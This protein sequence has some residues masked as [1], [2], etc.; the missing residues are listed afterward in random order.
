MEEPCVDDLKIQLMQHLTAARDLAAKA[1]GEGRDLTG[2]ERAAVTEAMNQAKALKA[3]LDQKQADADLLHSVLALGEG[4]DLADPTAPQPRPVPAG[5]GRSA[6]E[7]FVEAPEFQTWLKSVAPS[8]R[9]AESTKG[10]TSPPVQFAGLKSLITGASDSSAGALVVPDRAP[11]ADIPFRPLTIRNLVTNGTTGSDTVE[12][13]RETSR[14]NNAAAVAE[15]TAA[16]G[17]TGTKPE[18]AF[19][20]EKVTEPVKTLAHWI[21]ATKRAMSD[22]A[23]IRTLLDSFLLSGLE[24]VLED[25]IVQGS[26]SGEHFTGVLNTSGTTAQAYSTDL[27]T[28]TRKALTACRTVGRA[29]PTAYVFHPADNEQIDL[30]REG[31]GSGAFLFGGPAQQGVQTLW[32]RPR[33]ESEAVPEGTGILADWRLA[34]LWDREQASVQVSDSHAD[35]F[36]RNL[37]AFL[38]EARAAFGVLR[39]AAFVEIDLTP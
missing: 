30:L 39:P 12:F 15:A 37:L 8:G 31:S 16:S 20:L 35:F 24:E 17:T 21:P 38:A 23:Q 32:G 22:A 18:S 28:T 33:I 26:G 10:L 11:F 7:R 34:V 2:E 27:L 6:G 1:D 4:L 3:R 5:K 25:E 29:V 9:I 36:V 19:N 13:V 14:V